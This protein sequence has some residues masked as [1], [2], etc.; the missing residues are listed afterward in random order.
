MT[1]R[2]ITILLCVFLCNSATID[3]AKIAKTALITGNSRSTGIDI[4]LSVKHDL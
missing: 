2:V 3:A 1:K 4:A